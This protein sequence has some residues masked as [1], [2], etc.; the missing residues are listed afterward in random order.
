MTLKFTK[1][2]ILDVILKDGIDSGVTYILS[3]INL[4]ND[5]VHF[6]RKKELKSLISVL[7]TRYNSKFQAAKRIKSRFEMKNAEQL[8]SEFVFDYRKLIIDN[9]DKL[10]MSNSGPGRPVIDFNMSDRSKRRDA[11]RI[12]AEL[13]HDSQRILNVCR[14]A[15]NYLGDRELNAILG[16]VAAS[17]AKIKKLIDTPQIVFKSKTPIEALQFMLKNSMSKRVYTDMRFVRG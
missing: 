5:N 1:R 8:D 10:K 15:A 17:P 14:Y 9:N 6:Q 4:C 2:E 13:K 3:K 11:S 7:R 16:E 12:S